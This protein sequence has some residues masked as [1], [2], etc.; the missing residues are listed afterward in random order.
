MIKE[1]LISMISERKQSAIVK[2]DGG[3]KASSGKSKEDQDSSYEG[4]LVTVSGGKKYLGKPGTGM[5]K[6]GFWDK[7]RKSLQRF[8]NRRYPELELEIDNL[9]VSRDLE[10]SANPSSSARVAGSKHGAGMAQDVYM[11]QNQCPKKC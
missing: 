11:Q 7:F 9:G 4:P 6:S 10:A 1:D 5:S 2:S 8:I 3:T